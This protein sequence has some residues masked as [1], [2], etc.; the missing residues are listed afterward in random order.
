M[1]ESASSSQELDNRKYIGPNK[2]GDNIDAERAALYVWD[3][4]S[5]W[6]RM[7]QPGASS[8]LTDAQL[9]ASA[10]PVS[11]ATAPTTPVTG[12][13]YQ[14]TQ[15]VS[16]SSVPSHAVTNAG[17]FAVQDTNTSSTASTNSVA[18]SVTNVT[19]LSSNASRK[20]ASIYND[21][22][23][24]S[25]YVKFGTTASATSYKIKIAAGGYYE[26]PYPV[27]T[28]RVDGIATAATGS[29]RISEES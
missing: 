19:L 3:G 16:L 1:A 8:G 13:F 6:V 23:A 26:F 5:A 12:T 9:R 15:P 28:G 11:L 24:A 4:V 27:Y 25:I 29:A 10:V 22:S 14:A 18:N 2:T 17:T 21:D 7:T 20:S